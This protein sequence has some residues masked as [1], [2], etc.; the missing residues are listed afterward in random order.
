MYIRTNKEDKTV[1]IFEDENSEKPIKTMTQDRFNEV[2]KAGKLDEELGLRG[3][4]MD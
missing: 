3:R 1:S 4:T 2:S